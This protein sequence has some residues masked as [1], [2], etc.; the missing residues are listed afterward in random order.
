MSPRHP[1]PAALS[2][3]IAT[4]LC[5]ALLGGCV[6]IPLGSVSSGTKPAGKQGASKTATGTIP[7]SPVGASQRSSY[8]QVTVTNARI[9]KKGGPQLLVGVEFKNVGMS[10]A[11]VPMPSDFTLKDAKG[12]VIRTSGTRPGTNLAGMRP[13]GPGYGGSTTFV[14]KVPSASAS[15]VF[16]CW[17][18]VDGKRRAKMS[19]TVP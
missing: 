3:T 17:P 8:W 16:T 12:A 15:Y 2:A 5:A 19:W 7:P 9:A 11:I 18:K 13:I 4:A 10:G 1:A 14:Y 6:M